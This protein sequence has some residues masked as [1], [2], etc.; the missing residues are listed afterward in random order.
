[1]A[2]LNPTLILTLDVIVHQQH[3]G[4]CKSMYI[5]L[6][7]LLFC[8]SKCYMVFETENL[9]PFSLLISLLYPWHWVLKVIWQAMAI[10]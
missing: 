6:P 2:P 8:C 1:M 9:F 5:Q 10:F 7:F 4:S 3:L